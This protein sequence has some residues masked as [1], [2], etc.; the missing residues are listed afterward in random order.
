MLVK[1]LQP[2]KKD[3]ERF[4]LVSHMPKKEILKYSDFDIR[5]TIDDAKK[6]LFGTL[7][8]E[9]FLKESNCETFEDYCIQNGCVKMEDGRYIFLG[10]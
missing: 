1:E 4:V 10:L 7:K 5:D 2:T 9:P 3:V 6:Y 8:I